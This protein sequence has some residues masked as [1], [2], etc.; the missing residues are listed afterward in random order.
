MFPHH[1]RPANG[2]YYSC[3]EFLL[4]RSHHQLM[5]VL[6]KLRGERKK[7]TKGWWCIKPLGAPSRSGQGFVA[8]LNPPHCESPDA[9]ADLA[10]GVARLLTW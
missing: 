6:R 10:G 4:Y 9:A 5:F 7:M 8:D 3:I 2:H 1:L